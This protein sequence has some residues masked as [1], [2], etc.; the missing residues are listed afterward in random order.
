MTN[1]SY[2]SARRSQQA[3]KL[4][5][6]AALNEFGHVTDIA[7][8]AECATR[9]GNYDHTHRSIAACLFE[10][11]REITSHVSDERIELVGT[12]ERDRQDAI[13]V[14]NVDVLVQA[15]F[16]FRVSGFGFGFGFSSF[17]K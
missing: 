15:S 6:V 2:D 8:G 11:L 10:R 14:G 3:G 7:A 1:Y 16:E 12:I 4:F 9:S 13:V 5:G 17:A